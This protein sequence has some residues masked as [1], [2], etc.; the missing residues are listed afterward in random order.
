MP[1]EQKFFADPRAVL[2]AITKI[3]QKQAA[4]ENAQ[5]Q[6]ASRSKSINAE[7]IAQI[8]RWQD[9]NTAAM[10]ASIAAIKQRE[11]IVAAATQA[12][13]K[14]QQ[15]EA[16][17]AYKFDQERLAHRQQVISRMTAM[18]NEHA[19]KSAAGFKGGGFRSTMANRAND[20]AVALARLSLLDREIE[21]YG[22]LGAAKQTAF[23]D[24]PNAPVGALVGG[25][26]ATGLAAATAVGQRSTRWAEDVSK[27]S[28]S[29]ADLELK[30][31]NQAD[32]T[33]G[34]AQERIRMVGGIT[35]A[36]PSISTLTGGVEMQTWLESAGLN[37]GDVSSGKMLNVIAEGLTTLNAF[38]KDKGFSSDKE[39]VRTIVGGAKAFGLGDTAEAVK[40][41]SDV[42][43]M[44]FKVSAMEAQHLPSFLKEG[45]SM[46]AFG[47]TP[48]Q[49]MGIFS[50][51]VS[52]GM[53]A[54]TSAVGMRTYATKLADVRGDGESEADAEE[55]KNKR[56]RILESLNLLQSDVQ[57]T[58]KN[59]IFKSLSKMRGAL[60]GKTE[61][62]RQT[63]MTGIFGSEQYAAISM[64][65]RDQDA[66]KGQAAAI[67][68]NSALGKTIAQSRRHQSFGRARQGIDT[69][70]ANWES[71]TKIGTTWQDIEQWQ[72][73]RYAERMSRATTT[74]QRAGAGM[75]DV[76]ISV[77]N[78][79]SKM[80]GK[81]P[82]D[83]APGLG[84]KRLE[85][86]L[87][88]NAVAAEKTAENI[89]QRERNRNG[90]V[91]NVNNN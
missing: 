29:M 15:D 24:I 11:K 77:G 56:A 72:G 71:G 70:I 75:E 91:E 68:D 62:E 3:E 73:K 67:G 35:R 44:G 5:K 41:M 1:V 49:S 53:P 78:W 84:A 28:F 83:I 45:A 27:S 52:S 65:L 14:A 88:R 57:V 81:T 18:E 87:E 17:S 33:K 16:R 80:F 39:S 2:D 47:V 21:R 54:E 51:M 85:E 19:A 60:A 26:A 59:D 89:M 34:Q 10:S 36:T 9:A 58:S 8:K 4:M 38:G 50:S 20:E 13:Q 69:E 74:G 30:L 64:M 23:E 22:K 86:L 25:M 31:M 61:E 66:M 42:M 40:H 12:S 48:E 79:F 7:Q 43:S 55:R 76:G 37:K 82:E 90:N 63:A 6:G 46:S 32:L